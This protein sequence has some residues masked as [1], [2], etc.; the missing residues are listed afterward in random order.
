[1]APAELGFADAEARRIIQMMKSLNDWEQH[2]LPVPATHTG[3]ELF[4]LL[5][6]RYLER[7]PNA[8]KTLYWGTEHASSGLRKTLRQLESDGWLVRERLSSDGRCR[9]LVP[10]ESLEALVA[11]YVQ[12]I[13]VAMTHALH[14]AARDHPPAAMDTAT[15]SD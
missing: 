11:N 8:L 4:F 7:T 14:K 1:M 5:A 12:T 13:R 10:T 9:S 3:R 2:Y 15:A 6:L